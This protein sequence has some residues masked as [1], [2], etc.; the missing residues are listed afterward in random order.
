MKPPRHLNRLTCS[1]LQ[2][3]RV[4][5]IRGS[6]GFTRLPEN[7]VDD[8]KPILEQFVRCLFWM[9]PDSNHSTG[10]NACINPMAWCGWQRACFWQTE[11]GVAF[12]Q[13]VMMIAYDNA[14]RCCPY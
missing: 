2:E 7:S 4:S 9:A 12:D 8:I 14:Q 13:Q 3:P 1:A 10:W 11:A 6:T 5:L